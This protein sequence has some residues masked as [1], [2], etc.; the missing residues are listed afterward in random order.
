MSRSARS[1]A[2]PQHLPE[3]PATSHHPPERPRRPRPHALATTPTKPKHPQRHRAL[4]TEN[5][6]Q[7]RRRKRQ[8]QRS[9]AR[10]H[11]RQ[12]LA[13]PTMSVTVAALHA[14]RVAP[15]THRRSI[16][17]DRRIRRLHWWPPRC[18]RR[19]PSAPSAPS[20]PAPTAPSAG[21]SDDQKTHPLTNWPP[22]HGNTGPSSTANTMATSPAG[23][24]L[25]STAPSQEGASRSLVAPREAIAT[26]PCT[27]SSPTAAAECGRPAAAESPSLTLTAI[28]SA[29]T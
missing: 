11:Q 27:V 19:P 2:A 3:D 5:P 12:Q 4:A 6:S 28:C 8:Q 10:C 25:M 16:Q 21:M 7:D 14:I 24:S 9:V 26:A 29:S 23:F 15:V 17:H 18:G 13:A 22:P 20:A 1:P